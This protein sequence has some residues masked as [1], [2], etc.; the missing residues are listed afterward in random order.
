MIVNLKKNFLFLCLLAILSLFLDRK[1]FS[2]HYL[3][4]HKTESL[5]KFTIKK[6]KTKAD[7]Q[8]QGYFSSLNKLHDNILSP[9]LSI[10]YTVPPVDIIKEGLENSKRFFQLKKSRYGA[11]IEPK[12][13]GKPHIIDKRNKSPKA[14]LADFGIYVLKKESKELVDSIN[15]VNVGSSVKQVKQV[16]NDGILEAPLKHPVTRPYVDSIKVCR[17]SLDSDGE[18]ESKKID[19]KFLQQ[20]GFAFNPVG[21]KRSYPYE[22]EVEVLGKGCKRFKNMSK[23]EYVPLG[24]HKKTKK[25]SNQSQN[26]RKR[27]LLPRDGKNE[28]KKVKLLDS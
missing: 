21:T 10:N 18:I 19:C 22:F 25:A 7:E 12:S 5:A 9:L 11:L 3:Q 6:E 15:A 2:L 14:H 26:S 27:K 17:K 4:K 24:K 28:E 13:K 16:Y 20:E 23:V 8:I 1:L